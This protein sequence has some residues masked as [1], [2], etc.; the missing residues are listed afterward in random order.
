MMEPAPEHIAA[1]IRSGR[2]PADEAFDRCLD[3]ELQVMSNSYWSQL[4]VAACAAR[5]LD[6]LGVETVVDVG[7]GAGKFCVATALATR[8]RFVGVEQRSRL[9]A[10][11][12]A[13]A[14]AFGV[15]DRVRFERGVFGED[16]VPRADLYYFYNPFGENL[17]PYEDR[18][19]LEVELS[20][21]QYV[22]CVTAAQDLLRRAPIGTYL[23]TYNGFGGHVPASY[24]PILSERRLPCVL[25]MW[26]KASELEHGE[27]ELACAE[28]GITLCTTPP[29]GARHGVSS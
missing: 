21:R 9:V 24:A 29:T 4:A 14:A 16:A 20:S 7:S 3:G 10:A 19:D 27:G 5:W 6:K 2:W 11:A 1:E 15:A 17:F 18:L 8:C 25:R 12:N 28:P 22:A 26:R 23:L 13:L